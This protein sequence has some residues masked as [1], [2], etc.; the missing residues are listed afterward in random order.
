MAEQNIVKKLSVKTIHGK[1]KASELDASGSILFRIMGVAMGAKSGESQ[2]GPWTALTGNFAAVKADGEII[3]ASELFLPDVILNMLL[4]AVE[5]GNNPE[6]VFDVGARPDE[7][8]TI[9]YSYFARP[10]IQDMEDPIARLTA[11][12]AALAAPEEKPEESKG[13]GKK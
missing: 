11:K 4:P 5:Q 8:V 10:V 7:N 12:V 2:F 1:V 3:R 6:F 9:G 13:K